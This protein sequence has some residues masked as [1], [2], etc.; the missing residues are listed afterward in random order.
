[1]KVVVSAYQ[2]GQTPEQN[3]KA[4]AALI[5]QLAGT[6]YKFSL[7]Q[8]VFNGTNETSLLVSGFTRVKEML[9]FAAKLCKAY[10]QESVY[11]EIA[12]EASL[13]DEDGRMRTIGT[14]SEYSAALVNS[15][16]FR[17]TYRSFTLMRDGSAFVAH[18][19]LE[20]AA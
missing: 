16:A 8:G 13:L 2:A 17:R 19:A 5:V 3:A 18:T 7:V 10:K 4:T 9:G 15:P 12:G 1:M 20:L 6:D 11:V 14:E